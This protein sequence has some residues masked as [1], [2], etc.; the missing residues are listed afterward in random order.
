MKKISILV[1]LIAIVVSGCVQFGET[2]PPA[3]V[4]VF[5]SFDKGDTWVEKN[6]FLHSGGVAS[7]NG[8]SVKELVFDPE[9]PRA[10]Y[11]NS[12]TS[13]LFYSYDSGESWQKANPIG[14]G[15]IESVAIDPLNKCVVYAT[16]ANTILKSVDCSRNWGEVYIDT[17]PDKL[18][19]A[20]AVDHVNNLIVYAGNSAGDIFKSLDGGSNWRVVE[21]LNNPVKK[22]MI[23]PEDSRVLYVATQSNGIYKSESAGADWYDLNDGLKPYSGSFEYKQLIF[24][25]TKSNSLMLVSKYGLIKTDDGGATWTPLTLIT[26]PASTDIFSVAI[27]RAN[28]QEIY[29]ATGSTFYKTFDGGENWVTKRL[30]STGYAAY[31]VNDPIDP[32]VLYMGMSN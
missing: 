14:D 5:K 30:P 6:L 22:I 8:V 18:V 11:L 20:L 29:Y 10:I 1:F 7:I 23:D 28:G 21:R 13:G 3:V 15:L 26:P 32:N 9:D 24:D 2:P 25:P 16:Y 19:T 17:R 27:N 31:M 12:K 4:G